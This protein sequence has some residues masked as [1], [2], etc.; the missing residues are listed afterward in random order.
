MNFDEKK[1]FL[2]VGEGFYT[3]R[4]DFKVRYILNV[5]TQMSLL[6]LN[7]GKFLMVDSVPIDNLVKAEIDRLT[8]NGNLLEAVVHSHPFHTMGIEAANKL[9]PNVPIFGCPRH[10]RNFPQLKWEGNL[11]DEAVRN[12]W[13]PDVS[14]R[15]PDGSD[16]E[17]TPNENV[18]FSSVFVFH[19]PSKTIHVD[20][21]LMYLSQ[22]NWFVRH[23]I[24]QGM[25]LHPTASRGG[26]LKTEEAPL[27]FLNFLKKIGNDWDFVNGVFAHKAVKL[28]T[29]KDEFLAFINHQEPILKRLSESY[30]K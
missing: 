14:M 1:K 23:L 10:I 13:E 12:K 17:T 9:Y 19:R 3:L 29:V 5:E 28:G 7:N 21:T 22:P 26:I 6:K 16:F 18:H 30:K 25:L 27:K 20:D 15:I 2:E 11:V 24:G 4:D 8:D